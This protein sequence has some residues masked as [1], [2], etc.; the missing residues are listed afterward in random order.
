MYIVAYV[1]TQLCINCTEWR[2]GEGEGTFL[3]IGSRLRC[4]LG[5]K[6]SFTKTENIHDPKPVLVYSSLALSTETPRLK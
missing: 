3:I 6:M 5:Y 1:G 4:I 2:V